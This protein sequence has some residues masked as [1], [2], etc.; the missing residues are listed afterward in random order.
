MVS[1]VFSARHAALE[2]IVIDMMVSRVV[3]L[4]IG[5]SGGNV[6]CGLYR[7]QTDNTGALEKAGH[8][9]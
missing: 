9:R 6:R 3:N 1:F 5:S 4:R 7:C 2:T 8:A